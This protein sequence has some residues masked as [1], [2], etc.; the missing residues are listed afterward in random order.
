MN[1]FS[2]CLSEQFFISSSILNDN[3]VGQSILGCR[4]F[5]FRTLNISCHSLLACKVSAEKS[6]DSLMGIPLCMTLF[7]S[8]C[9]QK[10]L[11]TFCHFNYVMSW[12]E[13]AWVH[14]VWDPLCFLFLDICFLQVWE[15]FSHNFLKYIFDALL[16]LSSPSETP[17]M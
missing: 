13:F 12:C 2:F 16:S 15:V 5:P 17:I 1:C 11:F 4:F 6:A 8:C 14:L 10:P 7:F 3:L 9:L